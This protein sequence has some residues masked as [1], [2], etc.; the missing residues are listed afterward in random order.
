[1]TML[2]DAIEA[3]RNGDKH[4]G[5][6]ILEQILETEDDN[7]E[8]WLWLS[9][10]VDSDEDREI[11]LENVIALNPDNIIAQKGLE[12]LRSGTFNVH[13]LTGAALEEKAKEEEIRIGSTFHDEFFGIDNDDSSDDDLEWPS[14]MGQNESKKASPKKSSGFKPNLRL[15]LLT[16]F[17]LVIVCGLGAAA[18]YN[19]FLAGGA[20]DGQPGEEAP[21]EAIDPDATPTETPTPE[22]TPTPTETPFLLPT[23]KPT[24]LPT[25]T[26]TPVVSPTPPGG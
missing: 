17:G 14:G 7:E 2:D 19:M 23:A 10:V 5:R 12:A 26:S 1:M 22:P 8:V 6:Q 3:I 21:A 9:S 20:T 24:D 11:C 18:A 4:G 15:I 13:N 16:V 25:P